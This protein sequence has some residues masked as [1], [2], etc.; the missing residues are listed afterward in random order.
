MPKLTHTLTR[1][2][3]ITL[4]LS[5]SAADLY[6]PP[7]KYI[8]PAS[9]KKH[10]PPTNAAVVGVSSA[11]PFIGPLAQQVPTIIVP[12]MTAEPTTAEQLLQQEDHDAAGTTSSSLTQNLEDQITLAVVTPAAATPGDVQEETTSPTKAA[13]P[14]ADEEFGWTY[15]AYLS[16]CR[17][18][19]NKALYLLGFSQDEFS[20]GLSKNRGKVSSFARQGIE[21]EYA[22]LV[23]IYT[24]AADTVNAQADKPVIDQAHILQKA[25]AD[26]QQYFDL[27]AQLQGGCQTH[28]LQI[29]DE[30][31]KKMEAAHTTRA[32]VAIDVPAL[33]IQHYLALIAAIN[34]TAKDTLNYAELADT[35]NAK[36]STFHT[37]SATLTTARNNVAPHFTTIQEILA[38][39]TTDSV[40]LPD[41]TLIAVDTAFAQAGKD[42]VLIAALAEDTARMMLG[43][44][45]QHQVDVRSHLP[46]KDHEGLGYCSDTYVTGSATRNNVRAKISKAKQALSTIAAAQKKEAEK[47]EEIVVTVP[48]A[49]DATK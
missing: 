13:M 47:K 34:R 1:A 36:L 37:D 2:L 11:Q 9:R 38:K 44:T 7:T 27:I 46:K 45:Q 49:T 39:C 25:Q 26:T 33:T 12:G 4:L 31:L 21:A 14:E 32:K 20:T 8:S 48:E 40:Q 16:T 42:A 22:N 17:G 24:T 41:N 28:S 43:Q 15:S 6:A 19:T 18:A 23:A 10:N 3:S 30:T 29:A 5:I 35:V